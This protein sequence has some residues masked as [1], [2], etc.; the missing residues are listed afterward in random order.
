MARLTGARNTDELIGTQF[1]ALFRETD[2]RVREELR[3]AVRSKFEC[4]TFFT[5]AIGPGNKKLYRMRTQCGIVE[6]NELRRIWGATRDVTE[7]KMAELAIEASERRFREVLENVHLPALMLNQH[8]DITFCNDALVAIAGPNRELLGQSWLGLIQDVR[9][10]GT[11]A[12]LLSKEFADEQSQLHFEGLLQLQ[13]AP[14]RLIVW[15]AVVLRDEDGEPVGLAAIGSDRT[16]QRMLEDRLAQAEKLEAVGRLAAGVAHDLNNSLT[17]IMSYLELGFGA[18]QHSGPMGKTLLGIQSATADCAL[19]AEQLLAIGR[20]QQLRPELLNVNAAI[21]AQRETLERI[22]GANIT[23][24]Q[25]LDAAVG[26]VWVDP[27]QVRRILINL[28]ANSRDAMPGGGTFTIS[29]TNVRVDTAPG[30]SPT[31]PAPGEYVRLV[32]MD[33]GSGLRDDVKRRLFEPFFTTKPPGKGAG[34][35][36]ATV[37]AIVTQSGGYISAWSPGVGTVIEIL[38]PR[39]WEAPPQTER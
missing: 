12:S 3:Q 10:R 4:A 33:S 32:V 26:L 2:E 21:A 31:G 18:V 13:D 35:G 30:A 34:L 11:W 37:H 14:P 24:V 36:L 29:T 27:V 17:L 25:D 6:N 38:L 23:V 15:D 19:L 28:A 20:R 5:T 7:L 1:S 8:G 9:E 39:R 16:E 22:V